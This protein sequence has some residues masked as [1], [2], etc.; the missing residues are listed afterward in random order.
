M[1]A[2]KNPKQKRPKNSKE[3]FYK[4]ESFPPNGGD[5]SKQSCKKFRKWEKLSKQTDNISNQYLETNLRVLF[6]LTSL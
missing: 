2:K 3:I 1:P 5:F 6:E 4:N